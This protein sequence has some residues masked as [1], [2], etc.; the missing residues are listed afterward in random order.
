M[1]ELHLLILLI[2]HCT[3]HRTAIAIAGMYYMLVT[4][5]TV[6]Y[7][8]ITP[9]TVLGRFSAMMMIIV[10]IIIVPQMTNELMEKLSRQR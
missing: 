9:Q 3:L 1:N 8:D 2:A 4:I 6:G 7:G 10:A 5:A